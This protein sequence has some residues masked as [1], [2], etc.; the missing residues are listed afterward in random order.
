MTY[1]EIKDKFQA[2]K[3]EFKF[4]RKLSGISLWNEAL[5]YDVAEQR[6]VM[7]IFKT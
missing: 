5:K 6:M 2:S 3:H 7:V 1:S 4:G